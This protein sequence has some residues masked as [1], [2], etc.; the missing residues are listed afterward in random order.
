MDKRLQKVRKRLFDDFPFYAKSALKIRTKEGA[1]QPLVLNAAQR[2]LDDAVSKQVAAE[3]KV[4][5]IILK[6]RQQG[7][8]TYT[9]GYLYHAVSQ[10]PARKAMVITHH[11]DSTRALFDMTKR[12]HENCPE[13]L[14]PHTKYSSRRELSFDVLSSSFVVATAGGDSVGRGETLTHLHASELAFW[15]KSTAADIWNGLLKRFRIPKAQLYSSKAR[16]TASPGS[17]TTSGV[18]RPQERTVSCRSSSRGSRTLTTGSL[19]Q[20]TSSVP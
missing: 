10:Q 20:L 3:G 2:I 9:G 17:S 19:Y 18:V 16:Q 7:L 6:A 15:N 13:I 1:I 11:A 4:R 8:S 5:V 14:R 12:Y